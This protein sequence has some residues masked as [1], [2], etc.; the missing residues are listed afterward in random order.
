MEIVKKG[1]GEPEFTVMGSIHGDEPAGKK[2][3]EQFLEEEHD[4]K[5]PVQFVIGNEKALED[6][7]RF[8]DS[9]LNRSFPGKPDSESYEERLASKIIDAVEGT[10]LLDIH[11]TR[12]YPLPFATCSTLNDEIWDM[13]AST[14]AKN[15]AYFPTEGGKLHEHVKG[16][17]VEAGFQE[18]DQAVENAKGVIKNFLTLQGVI[19]G[20][21]RRS[22]PQIFEVTGSI[23]GEW[24]F[25]A[26]N[27]KRVE[28]GE[29]YAVN[30]DNG[31]EASESFYPV[32][33]STNGYDGMLGYQAQRKEI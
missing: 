25:K 1:E 29:V 3:I 14:G 8:I 5:R 6:G 17:V 23:D 30:G 32:L 15:A 26:E 28:K 33:M 13:L 4:F 22:D 24:E 10:K 18:T 7:E 9:D 11:T 19:E 12:S 21:A 20:E 2:A 16:V 31:L 27:F